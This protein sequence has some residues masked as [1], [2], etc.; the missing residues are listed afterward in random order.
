LG[1]KQQFVLPRHIK[2]ANIHLLLSFFFIAR[3]L[4]NV[5]WSSKNIFLF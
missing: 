4:F 2:F 1:L 5:W 3:H